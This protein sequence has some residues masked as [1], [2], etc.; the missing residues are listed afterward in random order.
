MRYKELLEYKRDKTATNLGEQL[1]TTIMAATQSPIGN[2][3]QTLQ[4]IIPG[5]SP[6]SR[7]DDAEL[8]EIHA[9]LGAHIHEVLQFFEDADPTPNKQYTEWI[10][11][12]FIDGGIRYLE[13]VDST[14]AE[15]L[16]IYHEL[17][18]RRMIPPR[19]MDIGKI[20]G[21]T[22][23]NSVMRFFR[24][25]YNIYRELPEQQEKIDK[26]SSKE[27]YEDDEIR[28]VH[29]EDQKAAC[30]Y[31][32]GTQWCT[33]ST[34]SRN[35]FKDYNDDGELYIILPKKPGHTGEKYQLHFESDSFMNEND[36][37]VPLYSLV[38]RWPQL[39]KI[40]EEDI[41]IAYFGF[42]DVPRGNPSILLASPKTL[43]NWLDITDDEIVPKIEKELESPTSVFNWLELAGIEANIKD[44]INSPDLTSDMKFTAKKKLKWL[45][46]ITKFMSE[47]KQNTTGV[48]YTVIDDLDELERSLQ[49]HGDA[50]SIMINNIPRMFPGMDTMMNDIGDRYVTSDLRI[51][52]MNKV[53]YALTKELNP[54]FANAWDPLFKYR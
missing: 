4:R 36:V 11:R 47:N 29:P 52:V 16:A 9:A 33:A 42:E 10:I 2:T 23:T 28:I 49:N 34:K 32:Q 35:Y 40:F 7:P 48:I 19:L 45:D 22:G 27:V 20:K 1:I 51:K 25:V 53:W 31:G 30:Y 37:G 5:F 13:D 8:Q 18:K 43:E 24:D 54:Y 12:R 21:D 38:K 17:K 44:T 15:N 14:V 26:G 3:S 6:S 50:T 39:H 41:S 46:E